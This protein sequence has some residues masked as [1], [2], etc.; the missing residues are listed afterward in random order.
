MLCEDIRDGSRI[1]G[2][3]VLRYKSVGCALLMLSHCS[4]ISNE[5]EKFGLRPNYLIF[6]G[7]LKMDEQEW[8]SSEPP[9]DPPLD[10]FGD[11]NIVRWTGVRFTCYR[12]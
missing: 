2:K 3:G 5:N 10:I 7:Y 4:L 9:L 8:G 11:F 12:W 1:S 6:M